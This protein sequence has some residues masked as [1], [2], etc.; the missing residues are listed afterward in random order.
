[1]PLFT[2][3]IAPGAIPPLNYPPSPSFFPA[4]LLVAVISAVLFL[5]G[6][7]FALASS[8]AGYV[9]VSW[10]LLK[11]RSP[12]QSRYGSSAEFGKLVLLVILLWEMS[13][14]TVPGFGEWKELIKNLRPE[15]R[16]SELGPFGHFSPGTSTR[17]AFLLG[18][19]LG[20]HFLL[21]DNSSFLQ[22]GR[23][24]GGAL[25]GAWSALPSFT[26]TAETLVPWEQRQA[27]SWGGGW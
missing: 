8:C 3:R 16:V 24:K 18:F 1:M 13:A 11:R 21:A 27:K 6:L 15:S 4:V 5:E 23:F 2:P 10:G 25:A 26:L 19:C 20:L 7:R 12:L 14:L 22:V 17:A 9:Y